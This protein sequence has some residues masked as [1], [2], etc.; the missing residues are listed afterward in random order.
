MTGGTTKYQ[1]V[2]GFLS[3]D[4]LSALL[5]FALDN[6]A[7]FVPTRVVHSS[8]D[9]VD[10]DGRRS[11]KCRTGLG[12]LKAPLLAAMRATFAEGCAATGIAPF[13][14]AKIETELTAHGDGHFYHLHHDTLTQ[15]NRT[16]RTTDRMLSG[17][18]Y[19]HREP[20][21]FSGGEL[22]LHPFR[23]GDPVLVEPAN[24]RLLLFP[25]IAPHAVREV[26]C[27]ASSF[28]DS[29]FAVNCWFHR[30]REGA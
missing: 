25:S 9:V 26:H 30:A 20:K 16:G 28:A 22:A 23:G 1:I 29:R 19:F 2:D 27:P 5:D 21:R 24:N 11:L 6:E 10:R 15:A 4:L 18:F 14:V 12:P 13:T 3:P 7:G 17:V 8:A